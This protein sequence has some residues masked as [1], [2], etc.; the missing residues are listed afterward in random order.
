MRP[1]NLLLLHTS[2]DPPENLHRSHVRKPQL[3]ES[4]L[5]SYT[6]EVLLQSYNIETMLQ[7]YIKTLLQSTL[8]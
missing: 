2:P 6:I 4:L 3:I 1:P 7:Y 8:T 5:Q